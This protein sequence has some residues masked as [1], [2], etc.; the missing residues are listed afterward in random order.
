MTN[1]VKVPFQLFSQDQR[2]K[3]AEYV[4]PDVLI[5]LMVYRP[6]LKQRNDVSKDLLKLTNP[7]T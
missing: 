1:I 6:G 2:Q 5:T 7:C 4:A 3:A